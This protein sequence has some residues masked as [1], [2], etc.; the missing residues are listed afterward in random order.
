MARQPDVQYIQM[1]NYGSTARKLEPKA[2]EKKKRYQLPEQGVKAQNHVQPKPHSVLLSDPLSVCAVAAAVLLLI[3]LT[4]GM[5][6]IGILNSQRHELEAYI[7]DLR[8]QR[9]DLQAT[10]EQSYDLEQVEARARQMGMIAASEATHVKLE[11]PEAK[12]EEELTFA[13]QVRENIRELFAKA[14]H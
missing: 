2:P 14:P 4:V 7:L 12:A 13:Q 8:S 5:L 1:Y 11:L 6:Q 10:F 3:C 9:A